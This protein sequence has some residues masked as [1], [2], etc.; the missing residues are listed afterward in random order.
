MSTHES[1]LSKEFELERMI[2]FSDAVFA[3]AITLLIIEIKYPDVPNGTSNAELWTLFKPTIIGFLAF[4]LSF[5]FV[6]LLWSRHLEI[7]KYLKTYNKGVIFFNLLFLFFVVCFPF[8]ASGL[9]HFRPSFLLPVYIYF[10]NIALVFLSQ[11]ALCNY[12]FRR[13]DDLSKTG[14]GTEKNYIFLKSKYLAVALVITVFVIV[15][16]SLLFPVNN[17]KIVMGV[18]TFPFIMVILKRRLKRFKPVKFKQ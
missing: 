9:E 2:L 7:F 5:Y 4:V 17:A 14:Y 11:F 12:I 6:G 1:E 3:I 18:Y 15:I 10:I 8:T 16:L 13:R